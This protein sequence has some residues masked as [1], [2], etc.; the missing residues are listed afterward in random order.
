MCLC[1]YCP[2]EADNNHA[3]DGSRFTAFSLTGP[4]LNGKEGAGLFI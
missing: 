4:T 3:E 2:L 1:D